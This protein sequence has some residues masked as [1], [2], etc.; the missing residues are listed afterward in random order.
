MIDGTPYDALDDRREKEADR[1]D[2]VHQCLL[3]K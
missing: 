1:P 3:R 2:L